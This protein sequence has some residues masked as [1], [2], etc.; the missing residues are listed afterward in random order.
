MS[1]PLL[2]SGL[3]GQQALHVLLADDDDSDALLTLR[4]LRKLYPAGVA[5]QV[6]RAKDGAQ[7]LTK[8]FASVFGLVLLDWNMPYKGGADVLQAMRQQGLQTPVVV[9]SG[10]CPEEILP[11]LEIGGATFLSKNGMSVASLRAAIFGVMNLNQET[12]LV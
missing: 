9:I 4:C 8:L 2:E 3:C 10:R 5:I 12:V 6:E 7:A 1:I 11:D